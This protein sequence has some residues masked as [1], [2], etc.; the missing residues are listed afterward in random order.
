[1]DPEN[2]EIYTIESLADADWRRPIV[3]Y[4]RKPVGV[5]NRKVKY[6][7]LSYVV[8][9]NGLFKKTTKGVLLKYLN[10]EEAYLVVSSV[11]GGSCGSH[12]VRHNMRWL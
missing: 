12:Q 10:E 8:F 1:M 5:T 2:F 11:H 6:K 4:L 7:L 3:D 9:E